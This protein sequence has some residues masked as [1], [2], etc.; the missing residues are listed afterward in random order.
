MERLERTN[1]EETLMYAEG[2]AM[3]TEVAE[4]LQNIADIGFYSLKQNGIYINTSKGKSE[5]IQ[6]NRISEY[7][8]INRI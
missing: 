4:I 5:L 3:V 2:V 6:I 7:Y 8:R 1:G